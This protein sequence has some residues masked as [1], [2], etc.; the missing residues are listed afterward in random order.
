VL[1]SDRLIVTGSS[2]EALSISPY[3]GEILGRMELSSSAHLPAIVA[4]DTVYILSDDA[5]LTALR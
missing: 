2:G 1:A 5:V 3:T 4:G